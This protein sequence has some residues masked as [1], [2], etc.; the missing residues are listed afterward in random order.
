MVYQNLII[1]HLQVEGREERGGSHLF[2]YVGMLYGSEIVTIFKDGI[3]T[4]KQ[5]EPF[6]F[7]TAN[8][9]AAHGEVD[10]SIKKFS[11]RYCRASLKGCFHT[12]GHLY[13]EELV[14]ALLQY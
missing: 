10:S 11:F 9:G 2:Q 14:G 1:S 5:M 3:S 8:I 4:T 13:M 12:S 7:G 6:F